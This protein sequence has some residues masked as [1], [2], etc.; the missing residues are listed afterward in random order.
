[1]LDAAFTS[2]VFEES[3]D[4][5]V[6][7]F[8]L[9]FYPY[10][11]YVGVRAPK[12]DRRR[13]MLLTDKDQEVSIVTVDTAG[14]PVSR[15]KVLV[16][17]YKIEWKWWW[18]KSGESLAQYVSN[19]Q[20]RPCSRPRSRPGTAPANGRSRSATPTGGATSSGSRTR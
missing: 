8:S 9:P 5:S 18:D 20:T 17:L 12:G 1:M 16:S 14:R 7:T 19:V 15:D 2:R 11:S 13:G 3:G 4:F 10:D 6:D